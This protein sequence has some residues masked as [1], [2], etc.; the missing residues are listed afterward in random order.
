MKNLVMIA[1]LLF[2]FSVIAQNPGMNKRENK[3]EIHQKMK[4][5]TPEQAAVLRTKQMTLELDLS[6]AQ[7][8]Q[9]EKMELERAK[10]RKARFEI[11]KERS[12]LTADELAAKKIEMLDEQIKMKKK[13]KSILTE[14]QF[15]KWEKSIQNK[16]EHRKRKQFKKEGDP[17]NN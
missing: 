11:K 12:E 17:K 14:E 10:K 8:I 9:I 4:D 1:V 7:Q 6:E 15:Q 3:K 5:L 16:R 2:S 13:L